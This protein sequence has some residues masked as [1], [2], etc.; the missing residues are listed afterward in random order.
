V[1]CGTGGV[2]TLPRPAAA[3]GHQPRRGPGEAAALERSLPAVTDPADYLPSVAALGPEASRSPV[4]AAVLRLSV[5][6]EVRRPADAGAVDKE[7][8]CGS[9]GRGSRGKGKE[10]SGTGPPSANQAAP[11]RKPPPYRRHEVE[12]PGRRPARKG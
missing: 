6:A 12:A 9:A 8:N 1:S 3:P 5:A 11:A 10:N 2:H 7:A 4:T